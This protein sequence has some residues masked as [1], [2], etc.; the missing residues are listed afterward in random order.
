M[1]PTLTVALHTGLK[2]L[3]QAALSSQPRSGVFWGHHPEVELVGQW[4]LEHHTQVSASMSEG[5]PRNQ[6]G[7]KRL[8]SK[9]EQGWHGHPGGWPVQG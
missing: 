3:G 7:S 6:A 5:T 9:A 4:R 8:Q 1:S 2:I